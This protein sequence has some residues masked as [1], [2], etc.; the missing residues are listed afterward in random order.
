M[1]LREVLQ[2]LATLPTER[3]PQ[4]AGKRPD[5]LSALRVALEVESVAPLSADDA[6][7][8]LLKLEEV[9]GLRFRRVFLLG[10]TDGVL[11]ARID[12]G[13]LRGKRLQVPALRA[14]W[15]Q[16]DTGAHHYFAQ[17]FQAAEDMVTI[18][19]PTQGEDGEAL[20]SDLWAATD[21]E[22]LVPLAL[23]VCPRDAACRLGRAFAGSQ[24]WP[25][26]AGK[27]DGLLPVLHAWQA[28]PHEIRIEAPALLRLR[29]PD[30]GHFTPSD[31]ETYAACPF[32]YFGLNVL[33]LEERDPDRTR[34]VYG[35]LVHRLLYRFYE[36]RRAACPDGS[37]LPATAVTQRADL[38]RLFE[39]EWDAVDDGALPPDLQTVFAHEQGVIGLLL[40]AVALIERV[41]GNLLNEFTLVD[42]E[43]K[44]VR[45]GE[46]RDGR[47]VFLTG[48]I[49][50]VDAHREGN[51]QAVIIDY[52][53]GAALPRREVEHKMADGRMLQLALYAWLLQQV[54]PALRVVGGAYVHLSER[55]RKVNDAILAAGDWLAH[56]RFFPFD[57]EDARR[58]ALNMVSDIRAGD[59][60][61]TKHADGP[62]GECTTF[63]ALRHACRQ[64][65]GYRMR[66]TTS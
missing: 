28:R 25:A 48:Q 19:R 26:V 8:Q 63:C 7:V 51:G 35:S 64:P 60:S 61:L 17:V 20:P 55:Q 12:Y 45:L 36:R 62:L 23:V 42:G 47:P 53:T 30:G 15:A 50:R 43:K 33:R 41:H 40:E 37:P 1:H 57:T 10:L 46:D 11:P 3:V 18:S 31:L 66:L 21:A 6:G 9:A 34:I 4:T 54:R 49:D 13:P 32:R 39:E 44:P 2:S 38:L 56:G 5:A 24:S 22:T 59:F 14:Q 58:T 65:D 29:F 16:R 27:L 52:K